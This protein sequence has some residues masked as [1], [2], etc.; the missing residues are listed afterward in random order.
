[1][2]QEATVRIND[3][4]YKFLD[5]ESRYLALF[6][7]AGSGKSVFASQK[8]VTRI[9]SEPGHNFLALRK[10]GKTIKKSVFAEIKARLIEWNIYNQF[11]INKTDFSFIHNGT[12]SEITC[13]GLDEP[14]KIK[15][16]SGI[17]GMWLEEAT[18]FDQED[19]DQLRLRIR[20]HKPNYVQFI[21]T[22]NPIDEDHWLNAWI[23]SKPEGLTFDISTY[24]ANEEF[25]DSEYIDML[26]EFQNTNTLYYQIYVLA[27]WG[28][29]DKTNKFFHLWDKVKHVDGLIEYK[30]DDPLWLSFDFNVDP[31]TCI[32][33][34][35]PDRDTIYV[36]DEIR[37]NNSSVHAVTDYIQAKYKNYYW[38]VTGDATGSRRSSTSRDKRSH[39]Q[40]IK[41]ELSLGDAQIKVR[42][43]N[44]GHITSRILCNAVLE[45]KTIKMHPR[46]TNTINDCVGAKIDDNQKLYKTAKSGL[47]FCDV[48]RYLLGANFPEI[49]K[50]KK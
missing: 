49:M 50:I 30:Q 22:F 15:S 44:L 24:H 5:D 26:E 4:F 12:K 41:K 42:S 32:V 40:I 2:S 25:L 8:V 34:Q 48:F 7:G 39:W 6:G 20:G 47:H 45:H 13:T 46:C 31:M 28:V 37:M 18:E 11:T 14:E 16:I 1:M 23:D 21:L 27:E 29:K 43:V 38:I 9:V 10:V 19:W 33:A 36:L 3:H 35:T 17:T